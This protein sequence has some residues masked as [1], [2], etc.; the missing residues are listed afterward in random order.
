M[1]YYINKKTV[2]ILSV[3]A[4]CILLLWLFGLGFGH[5]TRL[6]KQTGATLFGSDVYLGTW[7]VFMMF[8]PVGFGVPYCVVRFVLRESIQ[9]YGFS[10]GDIKEGVMLMLILIPA[11]VLAPLVSAYIGTERYYTYL[12][13]PGFL[14]PLTV[15]LHAISYGSFVF[16][17]EFLFRGFLLFGLYQGMNET[18]ISKWI[19]V[20]TSAALSAFCLMGL[21]W[22]FPISALLAGIPL[23][24]VNVRM[25]SIAYAAFFHWNVGVWSDIWEIIKLNIAH[26]HKMW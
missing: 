12:T 21:P 9:D 5:E 2:V 17:F 1:N 13:E 6:S 8:I 15:A 4:F 26:A 20:A 3:T 24:L 18:R 19:A 14:K 11:Y 10:L 23:G 16:G 25:R 7:F 22:V